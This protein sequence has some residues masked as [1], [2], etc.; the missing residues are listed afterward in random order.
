[1]GGK[2][3]FRSPQKEVNAK[4]GDEIEDPVTAQAETIVNP[5]LAAARATV[6][7]RPTTPGGSS[8]GTG[9]TRRDVSVPSSTS[10][11]CPVRFLQ[12]L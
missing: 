2:Y 3:S 7:G 6:A 11:F 1:M 4:E 8:G 12:R 10:S 9:S 5:P